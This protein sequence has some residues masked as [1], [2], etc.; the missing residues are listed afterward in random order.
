MNTMP[1][2]IPFHPS[3]F[4]LPYGDYGIEFEPID[5]RSTK[6]VRD[7]SDAPKFAI[8]LNS[9]SEFANFQDLGEEEL[10]PEEPS[11]GLSPALLN[12]GHYS[13]PISVGFTG[14]DTTSR[15]M[16]SSNSFGVSSQSPSRIQLFA[17]D[18]SPVVGMSATGVNLDRTGHFSYEVSY[19]AIQEESKTD[20]DSWDRV[21][22]FAKY[23]GISLQKPRGMAFKPQ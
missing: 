15:H 2:L 21:N 9:E 16:R 14:R 20:L 7:Y 18:D 23:T 8:Y 10:M 3:T 5:F 17:N 6:K 11:S 13:R 4:D 22:E 12:H 1:R 19:E